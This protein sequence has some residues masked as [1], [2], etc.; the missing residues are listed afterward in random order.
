MKV[1]MVVE[2][3]AYEGSRVEKVFSDEEKA[4]AYKAQMMIEYCE[5]WD[6]DIEDADY[7]VEV[8]AMDVE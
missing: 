3:W 5:D 8:V 4:K 7:Y 2:G 6:E 1:Y